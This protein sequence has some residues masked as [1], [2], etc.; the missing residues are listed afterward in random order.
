YRGTMDIDLVIQVDKNRLVDA[1]TISQT[2][3][4]KHPQQFAKKDIGYGVFVPAVRIIGD[5]GQNKLVEVEIFDFESWRNRPQ[6]DLSRPD[7]DRVTLPVNDTA[8]AVLSP[9]WLLREKILSQYQRQGNRKEISDIE[10][11]TTL[12]RLVPAKCL[13]FSSAELI[14][15]LRNLLESSRS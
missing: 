12:L 3:Y 14:A 13:S 11:I 4:T 8:V 10:D 7:N 2:L 5:N 6:Y 9:R 15:A 1:D